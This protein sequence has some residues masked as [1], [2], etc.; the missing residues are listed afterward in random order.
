MLLSEVRTRTAKI[1]VNFLCADDKKWLGE[2]ISSRKKTSRELSE[3]FGISMKL[4]QKYKRKL[5]NG[6]VF[7]ETNG[8]LTLLSP[9]NEEKLCVKEISTRHRWNIMLR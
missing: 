1:D 4:L 6:D 7:S 2:Q 3:K 5:D 9:E 8:R